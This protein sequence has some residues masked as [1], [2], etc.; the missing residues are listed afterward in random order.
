MAGLERNAVR[1]AALLKAIANPARLVVLCQLAEGERSVR[2]L[3]RVVGLS[4]SG[5]S[6]HLAVLR[7]GGVVKSR[8]HGQAVLYSL[9]DRDVVTLMD[10][11][12]ALFCRRSGARGG[13][14]LRVGAV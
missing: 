14:R 9:A 12:Y 10:T 4:Q 2:E 5:I 8:R 1:V 7:R 11:L 13:A 6:Q 3:E